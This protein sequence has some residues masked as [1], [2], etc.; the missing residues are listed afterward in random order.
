MRHFFWVSAVCKITHLGVK[1]FPRIH[2]LIHN[3]L[4]ILNVSCDEVNL[5][6]ACH[7]PFYSTVCVL[8]NVQEADIRYNYEKKFRRH[9]MFIHTLFLKTKTKK[10]KYLL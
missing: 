9:L 1:G 10:A 4:E 2:G 8:Q 7:A 3:E 5:N 6:V